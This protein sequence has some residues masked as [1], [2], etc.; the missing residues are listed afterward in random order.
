MQNIVYWNTSDSPPASVQIAW[1]F[2][3]GN[4]GAQ[5]A[6]GAL[7]ATGSTTVTITGVNVAPVITA[8][9]S[10]GMVRNTSFT[11]SRALGR[12]LSFSD[13]D[14]A[15]GQAQATLS[16][17]QGTLTLAQTTGLSFTTGDGTADATLVFTGTAAAINAALDGLVYTPTAGYV[18]SDALAITVSDQGN[19][20]SGGALSDTET[21]AISVGTHS[22]LQGQYVEMGVRQ[23][24]NFGA[25]TAPPPGFFTPV[26][27][28]PSGTF[29]IYADYDRNGWSVGTPPHTGDF[30]SY[31]QEWGINVGGTTY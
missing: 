4:S 1:T 28:Y 25:D 29:G 27:T 8:L 9:A 16:V 5:G 23:T 30:A 26:S 31:A 19:T 6:G 13:S 15:S 3:D 17:T 21:V 14:I 10:A 22:F 18:G 24:G 12:E 20:G 11:F 7:S 2:S